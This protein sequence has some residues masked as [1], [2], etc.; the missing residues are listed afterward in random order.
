MSKAFSLIEVIFMIVVISIVASVAV[1][2]LMETKDNAVVSSIQQDIVTVTNSIKTYYLQNGK[3]Q[4]ISDAVTLNSSVWKI[5]QD[6][7]QYIENN[8]VCVSIKVSQNILQLSINSS[9]GT[10]CEMLT[11]N[12]IVPMTQ[13]LR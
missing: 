10:I 11:Q 13:A 6:E 12:G 2:K 8:T 4:N 1:P 9:A 7:I 3:I 5:S